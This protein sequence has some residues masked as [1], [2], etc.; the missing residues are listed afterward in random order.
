MPLL[1]QTT[2]IRDRDLKE[3]VLLLMEVT[4]TIRV[5]AQPMEITTTA[6]GQVHQI[7]TVDQTHR[8]ITTAEIHL[9]I[10]ADQTLQVAVIVDLIH[11]VVIIA[12]QV[13]QVV[14]TIVDQTLRAVREVAIAAVAEAV[15]AV[16]ALVVD[17]SSNLFETHDVYK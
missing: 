6:V 4:V 16:V 2:T 12:D 7:I 9:E 8:A 17:N 5:A 10:I 3:P 14:T 13:L 15:V 1:I 11:Q